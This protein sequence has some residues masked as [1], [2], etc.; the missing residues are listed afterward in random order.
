MGHLR[1]GANPLSILQ[2]AVV[3]CDHHTFIALYPFNGQC[4]F[5]IPALVL[6]GCWFD[7]SMSECGIT[8]R[9]LISSFASYLY[10]GVGNGNL[11]STRMR[12]NLAASST[13]WPQSMLHSCFSNKEKDYSYNPSQ[14]ADL[15]LFL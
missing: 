11:A 1:N 2:E 6:T 7:Q 14:I 8:C 3:L 4:T 15:A 9:N 13:I 5:H 10:P 12:P